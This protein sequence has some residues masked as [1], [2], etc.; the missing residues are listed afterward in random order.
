MLTPWIRWNWRKKK[1]W[2]FC[3]FFVYLNLFHFFR[4]IRL[5]ISRPHSLTLD[6]KK[7]HL[8]TN[9]LLLHPVSTLN[10][11]Q[12]RFIHSHFFLSIT[13]IKQCWFWMALAYFFTQNNTLLTNSSI[14]LVLTVWT[15][16]YQ[17]G[18]KSSKLFV[19]VKKA[20]IQYISVKFIFNYTT[21]AR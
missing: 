7:G 14:P 1:A 6:S 12:R 11:H 4:T 18:S 15:D 5:K 10:Q 21:I 2:L 16:C 8:N 20:Q 17:H 9:Y 19:M 3:F 13:V